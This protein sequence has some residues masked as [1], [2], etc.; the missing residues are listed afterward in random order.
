[1]LTPAAGWKC[2]GLC[3]CMRAPCSLQVCVA[4]RACAWRAVAVGLFFPGRPRAE[5]VRYIDGGRPHI[6]PPMPVHDPDMAYI[7]I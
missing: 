5:H 4:G 3:M 2:A 1:M 6:S 7:Y